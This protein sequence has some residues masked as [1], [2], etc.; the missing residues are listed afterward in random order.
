VLLPVAAKYAAAH[1]AAVRRAGHRGAGPLLGSSLFRAIVEGRSGVCISRH[2][3]TDTWSLVK[4]PDR[5]VHLAV[6]EMLEELRALRSEPPR[7]ATRFPL[8]LMAGE[9]RTYNANQIYRDP[10]W[11]K[12]DRD[13]ALRMHPDDASGLGLVHGALAQCRSERDEITV[14]VQLDDTVRRGVV[15]LPHG[16]GQVH[17]GVGPIGPAVNRLTATDH[18]DALSKTPFHKYV[19]V[20]VSPRG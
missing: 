16:Y 14:V 19:P 4:T 8:L 20:R 1:G 17:D 18:C 15:T 2:E 7:D 13:G 5:R 11:R 12:V 3:F 9:R 6:P 10:A